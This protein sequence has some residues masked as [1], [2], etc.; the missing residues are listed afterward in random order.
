MLLTTKGL[1]EATRP[2]RRSLFS[3][4]P[5]SVCMV[6][7]FDTQLI[8]TMWSKSY[9]TTDTNAPK[10]TTKSSASASFHVLRLARAFMS[11]A[12]RAA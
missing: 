5:N 9:D 3:A 2:E 7:M 1:L 10:T 12:W 4:W 6:D 11:Y 8:N